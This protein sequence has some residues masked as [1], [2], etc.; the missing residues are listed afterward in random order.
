[1]HPQLSSSGAPSAGEAFEL[2]FEKEKSSNQNTK[3]QRHKPI[4]VFFSVLI[5]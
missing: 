4:L 3:D 5:I 1:V 2:L